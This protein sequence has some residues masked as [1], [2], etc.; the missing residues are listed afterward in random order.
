MYICV[1]VLLLRRQAKYCSV[2]VYLFV[3]FYVGPQMYFY[4]TSRGVH[5]Y[6]WP[7]AAIPPAPTLDMGEYV[8]LCGRYRGV[9]DEP[10]TQKTVLTNEISVYN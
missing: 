2:Y 5:I 7:R 3:C 10:L 1:Y 4:Y 8:A 9:V 6:I